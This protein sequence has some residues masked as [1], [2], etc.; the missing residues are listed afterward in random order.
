MNIINIIVEFR[1]WSVRFECKWIMICSSKL[2]C[3]ISLS[4]SLLLSFSFPKPFIVPCATSENWYISSAMS[5]AERKIWLEL[6]QVREYDTISLTRRTKAHVPAPSIQF[7]LLWIQFNA[8][9]RLQRVSIV[10]N[11]SDTCCD[12]ISFVCQWLSG[13]FGFLYI[14]FCSKWT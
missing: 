1:F 12:R 13:L 6:A 14:K 11:K 5:L 2:D 8:S 10:A 9:L 3:F 7:S 4:P